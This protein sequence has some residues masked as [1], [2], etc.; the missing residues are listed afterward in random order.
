MD[1]IH[2]LTDTRFLSNQIRKT[3][4]IAFMR[5]DILLCSYAPDPDEG[6]NYRLFASGNSGIG[7]G[8]CILS[9]SKIGSPIFLSALPYNFIHCSNRAIFRIT[10]TVQ[11]PVAIFKKRKGL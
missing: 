11:V 8:L 3:R 4:Q 2:T 1:R 5:D 10:Y 6:C 9:D 7:R